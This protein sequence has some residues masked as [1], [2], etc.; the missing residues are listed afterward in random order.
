MKEILERTIRDR[1]KTYNNLFTVNLDVDVCVDELG[2]YSFV[3]DC[4]PEDADKYFMNDCLREISGM[5]QLANC[6]QTKDNSDEMQKL[7]SA[8]HETL[9]VNKELAN[10]V[11]VLEKQYSIVLEE[12]DDARWEVCE[13]S[14]NGS[15]D[16]AVRISAKRGWS[17]NNPKGSV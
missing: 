2:L 10:S 12:R 5:L 1:V 14:S 4:E 15:I 13:L 16:D 3:Y 8:L 17:V 9:A 6:L 11:Y 7:R